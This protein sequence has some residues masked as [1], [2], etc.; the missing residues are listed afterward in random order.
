MANKEIISYMKE[1]LDVLSFFENNNSTFTFP[2]F[3]ID[4]SKVR[5]LSTF[6]LVPTFIL[7]KEKY[8]YISGQNANHDES[9]KIFINFHE[10]CNITYMPA[11][12]FYSIL[13]II[14]I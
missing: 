10:Y 11:N 9:Y 4:A 3:I 2:R 13:Y 12:I 14:I 6:E 8:E 7:S 1:E 5:V